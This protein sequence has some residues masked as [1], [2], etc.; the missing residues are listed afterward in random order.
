MLGRMAAEMEYE[1][2]DLI[3][4]PD[5]PNAAELIEAVFE[6]LAERGAPDRRRP[7]R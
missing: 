5:R 2:L 6:F 3:E 4:Q 1:L 7:A